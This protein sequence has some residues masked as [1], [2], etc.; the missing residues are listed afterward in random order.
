V[1]VS[2]A[3]GIPAD[4][5]SDADVGERSRGLGVEDATFQAPA[6]SGRPGDPPLTEA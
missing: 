5:Y 3:N 1:A 6:A 2:A 4:T